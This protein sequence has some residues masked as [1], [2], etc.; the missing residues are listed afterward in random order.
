MKGRDREEGERQRGWGET[1]RKGRERLRGKGDT[2]S[3]GMV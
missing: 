2:E 3:E 1:E